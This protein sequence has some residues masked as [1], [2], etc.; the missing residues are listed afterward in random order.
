M[1]I[2]FLAAA[3]AALGSAP[4][5]VPVEAPTILVEPAQDAGKRTKILT[6]V[7]AAA[8]AVAVASDSDETLEIYP[9]QFAAGGRAEGGPQF[10]FGGVGLSFAA[11]RSKVPSDPLGLVNFKNDSRAMGRFMPGYPQPAKVVLGVKVS[12]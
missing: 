2:G 6:A 8:A 1:S 5:A 10:R 7:A 11:Y 12:F 9:M 3:L 4:E